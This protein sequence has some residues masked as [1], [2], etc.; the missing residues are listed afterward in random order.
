MQQNNCPI[1]G[2]ELIKMENKRLKK[3][4]IA[5]SIK[6]PLDR[7]SGIWRKIKW[8]FKKEKKF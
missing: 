5:F 3:R 8:M 4:T 2:K 7:L 6:I 1:S